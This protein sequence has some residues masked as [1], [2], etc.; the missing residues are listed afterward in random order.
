MS[1]L[2]LDASDNLGH[3]SVASVK[4]RASGEWGVGGEGGSVVDRGEAWL[5]RRWAASAR[6]T[7]WQLC[8]DRLS[9]ESSD[10]QESGVSVIMRC[11]ALPVKF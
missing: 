8:T 1:P 11:L 3:P 5:P 7:D 6:L 10:L 4:G 9:R 2:D